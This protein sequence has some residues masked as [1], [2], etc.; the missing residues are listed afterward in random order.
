VRIR[1]VLAAA[2]TAWAGSQPGM[3]MQ[4]AAAGS[5]A[6]LVVDGDVAKPLSLTSVRMLRRIQIVQV[7]K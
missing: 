6:V 2:L 1:F 4:P 7:R 3:A 5:Q